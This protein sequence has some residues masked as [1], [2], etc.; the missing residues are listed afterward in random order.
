MSKQTAYEA[1]CELSDKKGRNKDGKYEITFDELAQITQDHMGKPK[2]LTMK[3]L[4][5]LEDEQSTRK[6]G[7]KK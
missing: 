7:Y 4:K 6:E 3:L 2:E 1:L 5:E